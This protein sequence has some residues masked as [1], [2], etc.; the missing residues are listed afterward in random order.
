MIFAFGL[1]MLWDA[2]L[3]GKNGKL[4]E[5]AYFAYASAT[6]NSNVPPSQ[7][8]HAQCIAI[9]KHLSM[10]LDFNQRAR[11]H[12]QPLTLYDQMRPCHLID[13]LLYPYLHQ[14]RII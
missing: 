3:K 14:M 13:T 8:W 1:S 9:A 4:M 10:R 5:A 6:C 12:Q 7:W 11:A 2:C